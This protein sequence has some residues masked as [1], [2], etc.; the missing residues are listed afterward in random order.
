MNL[1]LS[2]ELTNIAFKYAHTFFNFPQRY[3]FTISKAAC[4]I[5]GVNT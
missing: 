1:P 2:K 4:D 5:R 3:S